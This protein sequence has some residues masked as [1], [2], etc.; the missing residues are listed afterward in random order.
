MGGDLGWA[1]LRLLTGWLYL[2]QSESFPHVSMGKL[3]KSV[4]LGSATA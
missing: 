1:K 2:R 3:L 4:T